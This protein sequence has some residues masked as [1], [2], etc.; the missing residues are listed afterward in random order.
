MEVYIPRAPVSP[1]VRLI[2]RKS[3]VTQVRVTKLMNP[4]ETDRREE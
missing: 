1:G 4:G 2:D 3:Q